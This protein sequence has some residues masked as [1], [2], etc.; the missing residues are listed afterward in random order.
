MYDT[1]L[2]QAIQDLQQ[3]FRETAYHQL[4]QV[5]GRLPCHD[6]VECRP[7]ETFEAHHGP[8]LLFVEIESA[9]EAWMIQVLEQGKFLAGLVDHLALLR[10]QLLQCHDLAI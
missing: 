7:L 8:A 3:L 2:V 9:D 10:H 4:G 6:Y 5:A 1:V